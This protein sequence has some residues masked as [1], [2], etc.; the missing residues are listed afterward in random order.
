MASY[1]FFAIFLTTVL[2]ASITPGPSMLLALNHGVSFG[3]RRSLSTA[4][5]NVCATALQCLVSFAGLGFILAQAAWVF[6]VTRY[7]GAA[8]LV[9]LGCRLLFGPAE[10]LTGD[11]LAGQ[12]R[13]NLFR[14]AFV[15]TASNPKALIFFSALF[16]QFFADGSLS[17]AKAAVMLVTVLVTTFGCMMLYATAGAR[18]QG[19]FRRPR[20]R[21]L[22]QRGV[23]ATLA[24][25]GVGLALERR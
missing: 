24:F 19:L 12:P 4:W 1:S 25:L 15:V 9:Y 18:I 7:A 5:G 13:R 11:N 10:A 22:F 2:V 8:Y 6:S 23:G 16:P 3:W 20:F 14:E 17:T 21:T